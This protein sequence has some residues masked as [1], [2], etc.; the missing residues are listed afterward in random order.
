MPARFDLITIDTADTERL[1]AFW[2]AALLLHESQREDDGRWIVLSTAD[3]IRRIGLQRG[4]HRP[5]GPHV[6]LICD[7]AEF[8]VERLRLIGLGAVEQQPS[9]VEPYGFIVNLADPDSNLF[10]L[11]AYAP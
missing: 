10:D 7:V 6:D 5:G 9:R 2:C 4:A 1:A 8:D 3:R 11:C